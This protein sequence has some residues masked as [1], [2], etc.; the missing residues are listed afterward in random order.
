MYAFMF[1]LDLMGVVV[2]AISGALVASR[3]EMD[4]IGFGLMASLT[5]VGG[6]TLAGPLLLG[7]AG[8]LDRRAVEPVMLCLGVAVTVIYFTAHSDSSGGIR[9]C[10]GPMVLVHRAL[11]RDGRRVGNA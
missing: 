9:S 2:F 1:T 4:L 11:R 10:C 7:P 6:G 8:V 5:G 3:K